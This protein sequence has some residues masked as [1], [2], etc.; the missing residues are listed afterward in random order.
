MQDSNITIL[1]VIVGVL[2]VIVGWLLWAM[3]QI[4]QAIKAILKWMGIQTDKQD[5]EKEKFRFN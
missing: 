5:E 4:L 1:A 3:I 2:C